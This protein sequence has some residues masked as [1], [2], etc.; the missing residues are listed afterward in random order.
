VK[1]ISGSTVGSRPRIDWRGWIALAWVIGW[2]W[3]YAAMAFQA[4]APQV[5]AWF[6]TIWR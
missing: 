3:A 5:L 1:E 2:G 6:R 4:R